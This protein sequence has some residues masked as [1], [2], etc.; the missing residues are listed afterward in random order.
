M[1]HDDNEDGAVRW[2]VRDGGVV[3]DGRLRMIRRDDDLGSNDMRVG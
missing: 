3:V 1:M 2:A